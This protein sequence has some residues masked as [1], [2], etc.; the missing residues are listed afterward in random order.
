MIQFREG[1]ALLVTFLLMLGSGIIGIIDT[2]NHSDGLITLIALIVTY[3]FLRNYK[4]K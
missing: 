2:G 4:W 1:T 3:N